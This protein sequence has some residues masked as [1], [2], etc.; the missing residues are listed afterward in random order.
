MG[1]DK[2]PRQYTY[3]GGKNKPVGHHECGPTGTRHRWPSLFSN[4]HYLPSVRG[5]FVKQIAA[6]DIATVRS[7]RGFLSGL[8][9]FACLVRNQGGLKPGMSRLES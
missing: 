9:A 8:I 3:I 6:T 5:Y 7:D 4:R 1:A 2:K